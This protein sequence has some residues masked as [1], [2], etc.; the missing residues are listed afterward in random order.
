MVMLIV[1]SARANHVNGDA[2]SC[3]CTH[4]N[5]VNGDVAD[6]DVG[7]FE[8]RVQLV[9]HRTGGLPKSRTMVT[10]AVEYSQEW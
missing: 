9:Q 4:A 7:G 10:Q 5:H 1:V 6:G 8:Q 2:N 3:E